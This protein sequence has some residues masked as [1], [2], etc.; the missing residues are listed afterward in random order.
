MITVHTP[1]LNRHSVMLQA[2]PQIW[3]SKTFP[4]VSHAYRASRFGDDTFHRSLY[5]V[6][7]A[8][9][10]KKPLRIET[11]AS[12]FKL[13]TLRQFRFVQQGDKLVVEKKTELGTQPIGMI[14]QG[15]YLPKSFR[16]VLPKGGETLYGTFESQKHP[17][18]HYFMLPG[19]EV[20]FPKG[21]SVKL[22]TNPLAKDS[23]ILE[24]VKAQP[25]TSQTEGILATKQKAPAQKPQA[26]DA[27]VFLLAGGFSSR[28]YP[29]TDRISSKT[30]AP[31]QPGLTIPGSV[32]AQLYQQ[33]ARHF[34]TAVHYKPEETLEGLHKSIT[35]F[36]KIEESTQAEGHSPLLEEPLRA[37]YL[38]ETQ[39]IGTAGSLL[40]LMQPK[41]RVHYPLKSLD[42]PSYNT[43]ETKAAQ[44]ALESTLQTRPMIVV[45]GDAVIKNMD[46]QAVLKAHQEAKKQHG[47]LATIVALQTDDATILPNFG[48]I[49]SSHPNQSGLIQ[50]FIEK[51]KDVS[52]LNQD[53]PTKP[54]HRLVNTG[55]YVLE[56]EVFARVNEHLKATHAKSDAPVD[57]GHDVFPLLIK[58]KVPLYTHVAEGTWSDVGNLSAYHHTLKHHHAHLAQLPETNP[59]KRIG[60]LMHTEPKQQ[61]APTIAVTPEARE[62]FAEDKQSI[63]MK[64]NILVAKAR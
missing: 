37:F 25:R 26:L 63:T 62:A 20:T 6:P 32:M 39:A 30:A 19:S 3:D 57:F 44:T 60:S 7:K 2:S 24:G 21:A 45:Q 54:P 15:K 29:F 58:Q 5:E 12:N 51:P 49:K 48:C 1:L 35:H 16:M 4:Q 42:A 46:F 59:F 9:T 18:T 53:D 14:T 10:P 31:L 23:Y 28:F 17:D 61:E 64:G 50:Q 8:V 47:A 33:G 36:K 38:H 34:V 11:L 40:G 13:D 43:H 41:N 27:N 52:V 22:F 55:I 56:P